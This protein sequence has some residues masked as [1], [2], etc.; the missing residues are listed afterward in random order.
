VAELIRAGADVNQ[1]T[2]ASYGLGLSAS[3]SPIVRAASSNYPQIIRMLVRAGADPNVCDAGDYYGT[4]LLNSIAFGHE[5]VVKELVAAGADVNQAAGRDGW[6]PLAYAKEKRLAR[7]VKI[8]E[9][10]SAS[11][12]RQFGSKEELGKAA[13]GGD[14]GAVKELI[15]RGADVNARCSFAPGNPTPLTLAATNGHAEVVRAL[16]KGGAGHGAVD[17]RGA[18][19]L[20]YAASAGHARV[21]RALLAAGADVDFRVREPYE[22]MVTPLVAAAEGGHRDVVE[23]LLAGGANARHRSRTGKTALSSAAA[24]GHAAVVDV[25]I[26]AV[27]NTWNHDRAFDTPLWWAVVNGHARCVKLL[28]EAGASPRATGF[29]EGK[30]IRAVDLARKR[31]KTK[32]LGLLDSASKAGVR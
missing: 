22:G 19:A 15:A 20:F 18:P 8:L 4:P 11:I 25:L 32:I 24:E 23:A 5:E 12:T 14:V 30:S 6:L 28:L 7:I 16:L 1:R 3:T 21:V 31:R 9:N 2:G 10:A 17:T 13:E 27:R 26:S 29:Y